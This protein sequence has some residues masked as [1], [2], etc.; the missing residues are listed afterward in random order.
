MKIVIFIPLLASF[1]LT[2]YV[3]PFWIKKAKQ[4]GLLW[5][6]MNKY[7]RPLVAG[8]GGIVAV[9]GFLLGV[10]AYIAIKTF[11]FKSSENIIEIFSLTTTI[12]FLAGVGFVDDLLGWQRGG[13]SIK[14]RL[15]MCVF[16]SIPL[17]VVNAGVSEM[18]LPF[19]GNIDFG[20]LYPLFLIPLGITGAGT[21]F[22]FLAGYNGLE[23]GQGIL[24]LSG[25]ALVT[26]L[27]GTTW[28]A[29]IC[30]LMV[31]ALLGF[32][33]YNQ[34][35]AKVF[36]GNSI[37]YTIGGLIACLAIFGNIEKIAVFFFIPYILEVF[38][39]ARGKLKKQSFGKPNKDD[40]LEMPYDKVYGLEHLAILMLKKLKGKVYEKDVVWLIHFMQIIVIVTGLYLFRA[41]IF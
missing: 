41:S 15:I 19:I 26:W 20:L 11:Y 37:T 1:L 21:T 32:W 31:M 8:S 13:L 4:I 10:L 9:I 40:S 18:S 25:L 7:K 30:L 28:L 33:F 16:A 27:T 22:N 14:V 24:V 39:K 5:Q 23:A 2:L 34:Y 38:L 36:P 12:L 35:P 17:V 3:I 6:D 29:V